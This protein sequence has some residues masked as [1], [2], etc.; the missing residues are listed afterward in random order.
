MIDY[1]RYGYS[2]VE[3][4]IMQ[5]L[6]REISEDMT[7]AEQFEMM[8][9]DGFKTKAERREQKREKQRR[10]PVRH[11]EGDFHEPTVAK[12]MKLKKGRNR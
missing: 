2:E 9:G 5:A 4:K 6:D 1:E 7:A 10:A 3:T 12:M 11:L 8:Y